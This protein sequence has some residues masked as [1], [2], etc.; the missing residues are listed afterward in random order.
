[1]RPW[2]VLLAVFAAAL[3]VVVGAI[4]V[5]TNRTYAPAQALPAQSE[6]ATAEFRRLDVRFPCG[7]TECA[8]WLYLPPSATK[9]GVIVMGHGFAGTRDVG[10]PFFAERFVRDGLAALVFDYRHFGASGGSPR[11]LVDPWRQLEDW[12]AAIAFIHSREEVDG[13]RIA[14]WGSSLGGG[15]ALVA[16]ARNSDVV[17]VVAQVPQI[18]TAVEGDATAVG[19]G[20]AIQLLLAAWTDLA[21]GAFG[22]EPV[23]I[24]AIAPTG[25]FAMISDDAAY[26]AFEV[27]TPGTEYQNAIAARSIFTFHGYNPAVLAKNLNVPALLIASRTD[28]FAPFAAVEAFA[29]AHPTATIEEVGGDHFDVYSTPNSE[30]AAKLASDFLT[31]RLIPAGR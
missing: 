29:K 20:K 19:A 9:P 18:D 21:A 10:L 4:V 6:T 17:C 23:T 26:K 11:Q 2:K 27:L 25:Q 16:A 5:G 8:A 15:L 3:A 1:M 7:D 22:P 30:P 28:R 31:S 14:L 12:K 24:K 13:T